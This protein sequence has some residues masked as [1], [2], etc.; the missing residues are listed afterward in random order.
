MHD[1]HA[2]HRFA[3]EGTADAVAGRCLNGA[4]ASGGRHA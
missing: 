4:A 2:V 3:D 1:P